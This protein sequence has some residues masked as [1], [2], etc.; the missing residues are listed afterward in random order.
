MGTPLVGIPRSILP[1]P[2]VAELELNSVIPP[3]D[4][5][6]RRGTDEGNSSS[7]VIQ[8]KVN[9][10]LGIVKKRNLHEGTVEFSWS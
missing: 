8:A 1:V 4:T 2:V 5:K 9:S 6:K 3:P 7:P 10:K